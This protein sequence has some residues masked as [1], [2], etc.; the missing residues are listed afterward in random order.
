MKTIR[1]AI[2]IAACLAA[3]GTANAQL[4]GLGGMLGGGKAST[5][6]ASGDI[7]ADVNSFLDK[8]ALTSAL[9]TRALLSINAAFASDEKLADKRAK[10][11]SLSG[12]TN[13]Q[14]L[15]AKSNELY[16]S[17]SAEAETR[18]SSGTME[19]EMKG[20]SAE[21]KK[22]IGQ[23]LLNFGIGGLQAVDLTKSGQAIVQGAAANPMNISK[24]A[25]VKDALPTLGKVASDAGGF[26]TGVVKLAKGANIAVVTPKADSKPVDVAVF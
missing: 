20:L 2:V 18:Y 24:V 26:L 13:P 7:T 23:A 4:G 17:E 21:K 16:K 11:A 5:G 12:I 15:L 9:S 10:L 6:K 19:Q 22:M 25:P 3:A 14:E 8:S 1:T